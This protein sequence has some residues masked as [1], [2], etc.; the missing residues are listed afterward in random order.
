M[1]PPFLVEPKLSACTHEGRRPYHLPCASD[2]FFVVQSYACVVLKGQPSFV[3]A[4]GRHAVF[5]RLPKGYVY[6]CDK[7]ERTHTVYPLVKE[8]RTR[9]LVTLPHGRDECQVQCIPFHVGLDP[10][11]RCSCTWTERPVKPIV[12]PSLTGVTVPG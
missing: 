2:L 9:C 3:D 6:H 12:R 7:L 1:D 5:S 4:S 10:W 11:W 8:A